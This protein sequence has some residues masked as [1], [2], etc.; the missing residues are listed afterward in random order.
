MS[1]ALLVYE[2]CGKH[3]ANANTDEIGADH[4]GCSESS[5]L[6]LENEFTFLLRN[7]NVA[8]FAGQFTMNGCPNATKIAPI[9]T[10]KYPWLTKVNRKIPPAHNPDPMIKDTRSPIV[11]MIKLAGKLLIEYTRKEAAI[12]ALTYVDDRS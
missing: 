3:K 1:K 4:D 8:T 10:K 2:N 9:R 7:Q 12:G 11:S 6:M 5:L